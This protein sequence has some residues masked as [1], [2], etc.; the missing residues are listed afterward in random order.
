MFKQHVKDKFASDDPFKSCFTTRFN[1]LFGT[2]MFLNLTELLGVHRVY[3]WPAC[4]P[5]RQLSERPDLCMCGSLVSWAPADLSEF[6]AQRS[7]F[8]PAAPLSADPAVDAR[9][10]HEETHVTIQHHNISTSNIQ[11]YLDRAELPII[12][13]V[14]LQTHI[15]S[16]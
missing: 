1:P 2:E 12:L 9:F 13:Q 16:L 11:L 6:A 3:S 10:L 7:L 8:L 14:S 4:G 5:L 15:Y